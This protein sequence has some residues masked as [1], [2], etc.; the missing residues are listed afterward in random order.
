MLKEM[1]SG[2]KALG[3]GEGSSVQQT[4]DGGFIVTGKGDDGVLLLKTNELGHIYNL[5][6]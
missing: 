6:D 5:D 1:K 4:L 2:E 3:Y